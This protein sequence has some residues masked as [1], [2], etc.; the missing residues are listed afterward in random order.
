M[1]TAGKGESAAPTL[2]RL[3]LAATHIWIIQ[4]AHDAAVSS[5]QGACDPIASEGSAP[6]WC[7]G[8]RPGCE[9]MQATLALVSRQGNHGRPAGRAE[10]RLHDD[11]DGVL[12]RVH[13]ALVLH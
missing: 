10:E 13:I 2:R 12:A 9:V 3:H 6:L 8:S 4:Q 11:H 7:F 5:A 1:Q